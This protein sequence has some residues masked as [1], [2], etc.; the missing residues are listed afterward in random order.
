VDYSD[1]VFRKAPK[2]RGPRSILAK[3]GLCHGTKVPYADNGHFGTM[4]LRSA[5]RILL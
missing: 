1:R 3:L 4:Y 5:L 2:K